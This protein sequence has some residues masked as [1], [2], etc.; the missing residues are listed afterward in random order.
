MYI[1]C[2]DKSLPPVKFLMDDDFFTENI[3][4]PTYPFALTEDEKQIAEEIMFTRQVNEAYY[5]PDILFPCYDTNTS[6]FYGTPSKTI[7]IKDYIELPNLQEVFFELMPEVMV[8][9]K[10]GVKYLQV[11][12]RIEFHPEFASN[13]PLVLIDR[14]PVSDIGELLT[15]SPTRISRIEL[16][17]EVYIKGTS[18]FGGIISI[19]T[20]EGDLAGIRLPENSMFFNYT[21]FDPQPNAGELKLVSLEPHHPDFRNTLFWK[22]DFSAR[23]GTEAQIK[24]NASDIAGEYVFLIRGVSLEG[25]I[26]WNSVNFEVR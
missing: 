8:L 18:K 23:P 26:V 3:S 19:F 24:F 16:V 11:K 15:I 25:K 14:I 7:Y 20:K 10:K 21:G 1:S 9:E 22:P 17:N 6:D 13:K 12:G 5:H 2:G 4:F